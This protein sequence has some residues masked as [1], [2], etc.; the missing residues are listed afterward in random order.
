M[1][2]IAPS[3]SRPSAFA[4]V[5]PIPRAEFHS[6]K[7]EHKAVSVRSS[8]V[9]A[10]HIREVVQ[11]S[12]SAALCKEL[13]FKSLQGPRLFQTLRAQGLAKA[14]EH[15]KSKA[16]KSFNDPEFL[17]QRRKNSEQQTNEAME[18]DEV[19]GSTDKSFLQPSN[20]LSS[21]E[22]IY[23]QLQF[24][25]ERLTHLNPAKMIELRDTLA[26]VRHLNGNQ[27]HYLSIVGS[28]L[29]DYTEISIQHLSRELI[30]T[31]IEQMNGIIEKPI[32][33]APRS[34]EE[35]LAYL[36]AV[37]SSIK[38]PS[39][40]NILLYEIILSE[41]GS[42]PNELLLSHLTGEELIDV[43]LQQRLHL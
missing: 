22:D 41:Y 13:Q 39:Y 36:K 42:I 16:K 33:D 12:D 19:W 32:P 40:I 6:K 26:Y 1:V 38:I 37:C 34:I 8:S 14:F 15:L 5:R 4:V 11:I 27:M 18:V 21:D 29:K 23:E 3:M 31:L 30:D 24:I 9:P 28:I 20:Y 35:K 17:K 7:E 43:F 25:I 2:D 10:M